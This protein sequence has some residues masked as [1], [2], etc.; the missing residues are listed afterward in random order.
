MTVNSYGHHDV[1]NDLVTMDPL[2]PEPVIATAMAAE[3]T[4]TIVTT[5]V[6]T[7]TAG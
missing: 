7:T 5:A 3:I 2:L 1:A 6:A 4:V